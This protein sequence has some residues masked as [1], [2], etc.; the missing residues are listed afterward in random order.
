MSGKINFPITFILSTGRTGTQFFSSYLNES[1]EDILCLHEPKPS[2]R[3]KWYSNFYLEQKVPENFIARQYLS[4]RKKIFNRKD[5]SHYVESSNFMFGNIPAIETIADNLSVIHLVREPVSYIRSHLNK[6]FWSGIKGITA[7]KVP[8]W[9][10][11]IDPDIRKSGDPVL[12]L[13]ARWIYVNQ[14]IDT[15]QQQFPYLLVRFEDLF[16]NNTQ[17]GIHTLNKVRDFLKCPEI[18]EKQQ[19]YWL[20]QTANQSKKQRAENYP[21][22]ARHLEYLRKNGAELLKKYDYTL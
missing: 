16:G 9:L 22:E 6:G 13:A 11:Y 12:I 4:C 21:V 7:R 10:E 19:R 3:F 5:F 17:T 20:T 14:V 8:G 18:D 2:R 1:C 15:Y